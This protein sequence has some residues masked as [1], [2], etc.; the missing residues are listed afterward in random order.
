MEEEIRPDW[1]YGKT[2]D[3]VL[4][5]QAFYRQHKLTYHNGSFYDI[6]GRV[7]NEGVLRQEIFRMVKMYYRSGLQTKVDNL[8]SALRMELLS[9]D[10]QRDMHLIH[11][12]NGTV[13]FRG[14]FTEYKYICGYRLPVTFTVEDYPPQQWLKFLDELLEPEDIL[15]LQEYMGYCLI[16]SNA[17]QKMLMII[18]EGGEGKSRIGVVMRAMLGDAMK[19]G[20]ISKVEHNPFARAD[21]QDVLLMVDDDLKLEAMASTHYLK[22]IITADTPMDLERKGE[23][24]YQGRLFCRFMAF[25]NGS[26]QALHDRSYGF[27]RRQIVLTAKPR[28]PNRVDDPFLGEKLAEEAN[29]IFFWALDGLCRL[30]QNNFRFTISQRSK[31]NW[32]QVVKESNNIV[33]FLDSEGYIRL[34]EEESC[35]S[36]QLYARYEDWCED[37]ALRPLS[38][39]SFWTFMSSQARTYNLTPTNNIY[40]GNGKRAR[41]F[42][43]I[44]T[45]TQF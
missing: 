36:R 29:A 19:N 17:A 18:G 44:G 45:V 27:F 7:H 31:S 23:Q 21:L 11:V 42:Y 6:N 10:I 20:S 25:G 14:D 12:A 26:L 9:D 40:I 28:D 37:N 33:E 32:N 16:P 34:G 39:R 38:P 3:E 15:T 2:P 35:S 30:S 43:G 8:L 13:D 1:A 22:S 41:G 5:S 24:S 4:F